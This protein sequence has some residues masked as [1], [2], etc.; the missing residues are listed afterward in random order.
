MRYNEIFNEFFNEYNITSDA[1]LAK[2]LAWSQ[3]R[4]SQLRKSQ[5]DLTPKQLINLLK[6]IENYAKTLA[7]LNSRT[8]RKHKRNIYFLQLSGLCYLCWKN[9][10]AKYLERDELGI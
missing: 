8:S 1:E 4:V 2:V 10:K 7:Y 3:P 6:R 9:S 5:T